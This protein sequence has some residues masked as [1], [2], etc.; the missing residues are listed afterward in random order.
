MYDRYSN[1]YYNRYVIIMKISL[2]IINDFIILIY[3]YLL[4]FIFIV[5]LSS[6]ID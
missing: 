4:L 5:Y 1:F 3:K 2:Y 6:I